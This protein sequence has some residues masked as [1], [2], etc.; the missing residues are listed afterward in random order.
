M[1]IKGESRTLEAGDY[2]RAREGMVLSG[3]PD[4]RWDFLP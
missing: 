2:P 4:A 3:V 1:T